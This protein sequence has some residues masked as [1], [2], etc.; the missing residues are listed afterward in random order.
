[1]KV[2]KQGKVKFYEKSHIYKIGR[3]KLTSVTTFLGRYFAPFE[4]DKIA[5]IKAWQSRRQGIKGQGVRYWKAQW[6]K[7]AEDGT[8]VHAQLE[9]VV[10]GKTISTEELDDNNTAKFQL[11]KDWVER[12]LKTVGEPV[13]APEVI[14]YDENNL[15]AGQIDLLVHR[16]EIV[17]GKETARRVVDL[18]D[19]KTNKAIHMTGYKNKK[20]KEPIGD[21]DDCSFTKYTLQLS[22]YAY[23]LECQ[24]L[25]IGDLILLHL[26]PDGVNPMF[27]PYRRDLIEKLLKNKQEE[28]KKH[29]EETKCG[30]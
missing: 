14:I 28:E 24:G 4:V 22:M 27:V 3:D 7:S 6:K 25:I 18:I 9:N 13:T 5:K 15:L 21:M 12:Y 11:G 26:K 30:D 1:M 29:E 20:C 23:M 10:K 8:K 16:N 2:K 17:D 19:Y